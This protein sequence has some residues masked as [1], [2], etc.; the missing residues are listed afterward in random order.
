MEVGRLGG[1]RDALPA[2][3]DAH[4]AITKVVDVVV[5]AVVLCRCERLQVR[6]GEPLVQ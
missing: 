3:H 4:A 1:E 2:E 5:A 6:Q